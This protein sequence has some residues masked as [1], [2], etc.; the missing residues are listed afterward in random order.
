MAEQL[1]NEP[2]QVSTH[3]ADL[4]FGRYDAL[5]AQSQK[6]TSHIFGV[7]G[8]IDFDPQDPDIYVA[9]VRNILAGSDPTPVR[10]DIDFTNRCNNDCPPCFARDLRTK[11]PDEMPLSVGVKLLADLKKIGVDCVRF[12]GGGDPLKHQDFPTLVS[13]AGKSMRTVI[14]TNGD[15]L[16]NP[17]YIAAIAANAHRIRI[18]VDAGNNRARATTHRPDDPSHTYDQ[19]VSN[20][21]TLRNT[22]HRFDGRPSR[23][24]IGASFIY[25][26][27]NYESV[28][29]FLY[30]MGDVVD[31]VQIKPA[32]IE[33]RHP[34]NS[35][36]DQYV[37][38]EIEKQRSLP[39][40][41]VLHLPDRVSFSPAEELERCWTTQLRAFVLANSSVSVCNLV[42]N[43]QVPMAIMGSLAEGNQ[44]IQ[45]VLFS[46]EGRKRLSALQNLAP[47]GCV[48]CIDKVT[49]NML[50]HIGDTV[51]SYPR[52]SFQ[53]ARISQGNST[54]V[55]ELTDHV[56]E[57]TLAASDYHQFASGSVVQF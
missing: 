16:S 51:E 52:A 49:N 42:R 40:G 29:Q 37:R 8:I 35:K 18:S 1:I 5:V 47:A 17:G 20:M 39:S 44:T 55:G 4:S 36:I 13:Q 53:R 54:E 12:T 15:Y 6:G 7:N 30:D 23:L 26:Q 38:D 41:R 25:G 19:L 24:H 48:Y 50:Q 45:D 3:E 56:V 9:G 2:T 10:V 46:D 21:R 33:G 57:V 31:W 22:T 14:E 34:D 32:L 28:R 43:G 27:N 11:Y